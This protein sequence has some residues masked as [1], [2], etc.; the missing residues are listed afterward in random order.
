MRR[1]PSVSAVTIV[2]FLAAGT[3]RPA[4]AQ[5]S[6]TAPTTSPIQ[7]SIDRAAAQ[8][9]RAP[10]APATRPTP[11]RRSMTQGGGGGGM[12][13]ITLITTVAGLAATYFLVKEMQKKT[14]EVTT[15]K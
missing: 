15:P 6:A 1:A 14:D 4:L 11:V 7:A 12:M 3:L 9:A 5:T 8:A 13:M 2:A 10:L